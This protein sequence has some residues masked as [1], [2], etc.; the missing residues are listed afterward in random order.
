MSS[1]D[2]IRVAAVLDDLARAARVNPDDGTPD[3]GAQVFAAIERAGLMPLEQDVLNCPLNELLLE[4][5]FPGS[6][7][8]EFRVAV[9]ATL[10]V[11]TRQKTEPLGATSK[12]P[13]KGY[14]REFVPLPPALVAAVALYDRRGWTLRRVA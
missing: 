12:G 6:E 4:L 7:P 9:T 1:P 13:G 3:A 10:V 8:G 5:A 2:A 14:A 11:L